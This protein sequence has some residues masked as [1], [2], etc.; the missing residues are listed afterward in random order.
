MLLLRNVYI[1]MAEAVRPTKR[2]KK[3]KKPQSEARESL[4]IVA[5]DVAEKEKGSA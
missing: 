1:K 4:G 3:T 5:K 2:K